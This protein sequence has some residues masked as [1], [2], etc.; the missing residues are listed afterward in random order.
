MVK[1]TNV[2]C[3]QNVACCSLK[4]CKTRFTLEDRFKKECAINHIPIVGSA[5]S[6]LVCPPGSQDGRDEIPSSKMVIYISKVV[7]PKT[8]GLDGTVTQLTETKRND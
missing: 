7:R 5:S 2:G 4:Y 6:R 1:Y 8:Q 3:D